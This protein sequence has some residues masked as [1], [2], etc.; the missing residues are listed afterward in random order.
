MKELHKI[1][2]NLPILI[3]FYWLFC[4]LFLI[5][6]EYY[7][8]NF[9]LFDNIDTI[10]VSF[11]LIHFL[12]YYNTYNFNKRAFIISIVM[13]ICLNFCYFVMDE[14]SYYF[15]FFI[16]LFTPIIITIWKKMR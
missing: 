6:C 8:I 10:I 3:V 4:A 11:S 7:R 15:L 12:L 1:T 14:N 13:I 5:D 16:F 2:S 9:N